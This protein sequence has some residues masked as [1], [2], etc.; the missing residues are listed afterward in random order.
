MLQQKIF[1]SRGGWA[2]TPVLC[3]KTDQTQSFQVPNGWSPSGKMQSL[4]K[5]PLILNWI[6]LF[7]TPLKV[8]F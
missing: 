3:C 6:H 7:L 5:I 4:G 2:I 1:D 8:K